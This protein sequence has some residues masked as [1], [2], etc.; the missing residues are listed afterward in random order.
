MAKFTVSSVET[1]IAKGG[2]GP[3]QIRVIALCAVLLMFDGYDVGSIGYAV[4]ALAAAWKLPPE[5]FTLAIVAGG[6]GMLFGS[7]ISGILSDWYGRKKVLV[8]CALVFGLFSIGAALATSPAFLALMRFVVGIGLGGCIPAAV[9]L[10]S[11]Y[12]PNRNRALV[13]GLMTGGVPI[14]LVL[15]GLASAALIPAFGWQAIFVVGGV[16]P[17]A[18]LPVLLWF[19]PESVQMLLALG[20]AE[21]RAAK[22]LKAM[23][24]EAAAEAQPIAVA[25]S[26]RGV[27]RNPVGKLF[28]D[29]NA[30]RTVLLW[31]MFLCNFLSTWLVIFWLPTILNAAGATTG[32]AALFSAILSLGGLIGMAIIFV[33]APRV[34]VEWMLTAG[35]LIGG[36]AVLLLWSSA[37]TTGAIATLILITGAGIMGAQFGMNGLSGAV[38]TPTIRATGSGWAF[39]V[40]RIGNIIGPTLGGLVLGM[41]FAPRTMFLVAAVPLLIAAAATALLGRERGRAPF[42][43]VKPVGE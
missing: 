1:A 23:N 13:V 28:V 38:Y 39:G 10:T 4:P 2:F 37:E 9:A 18:L 31:T 17:L 40:G 5:A 21:A 11:D 43:T 19:L 25:E 32:S 33:T 34:G 12:V 35:L 29:G 20:K 30:R 16:L 15:G 3:L 41:S 26:S 8:G 24:L 14:G 36:V 42:D 22:L 6:V 7:M 27:E